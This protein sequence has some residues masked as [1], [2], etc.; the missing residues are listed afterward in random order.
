MAVRALAFD[1]FGTVVDWRSS[2]IAEL[3]AF[4][5][6]LGVQR[7]WAAFADDWRAGYPPAMDR[8]RRGELPWTKLDGLHRMILV[9]L[10]AEAGLEGVPD[11]AVDHLNRAWH[12][13]DPWPDAAAGLTRLKA[14]FVITT[15]SNGNVSLLTNMAKRAALPWDCVI[16]AELFG[17]Y[18]PDPEVY[19]G[20]ADL[21]DVAPDELML[22]AAHP[23]DLRGARR[24][25]LLT[26]YVDRPLEY[27]QSRPPRKITDGE[28]DVMARDFLDLADQLGA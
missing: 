6:S 3:E 7:D 26:A 27:G 21:L 1:T 23:S 18:K 10:L 16:S 14:R 19:L 5:R 11:A 4:G 25:G 9:D 15:L 13:L 20:C 22:V 24:A 12:R 8:V 28:F 17:H 2:V